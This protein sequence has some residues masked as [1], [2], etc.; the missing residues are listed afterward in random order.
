[1]NIKIGLKNKKKQK[2]YLL[3]EILFNLT[4]N[5][6]LADKIKMINE[7]IINEG[8]TKAA[9]IHSIS[10]TSNSGGKLD[11]IN[12]SSLNIKIKSALKN[13]KIGS[14]TEPILIPGGYLIL[15]INDIK[16]IEKKINYKKEFEKIKRAK[17]NEQLSQM[18]NLYF[19]R[20][21]KDFI[22]NEL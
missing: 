11:W 13:L 17:I 20:I 12:E 3:S 22:I 8:F 10:D 4:T 14:I 1:M 7:T 18:S 21:K 19:N 16:E 15:K 5:S 9:L 6:E 2:N